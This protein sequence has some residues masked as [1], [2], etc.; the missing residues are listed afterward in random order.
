MFPFLFSLNENMFETRYPIICAPMNQVFS[1]DFAQA[2][3]NSGLIYGVTGHCLSH[4]LD[5]LPPN[6]MYVLAQ[7]NLD[8]S[9]ISLLLESKVKYIEFGISLINRYEKEQIQKTFDILR[10]EGCYCICKVFLEI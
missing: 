8:E 1:I 4:S 7:N 6:Q 3:I 5:Q 2:C 10:K 9:I